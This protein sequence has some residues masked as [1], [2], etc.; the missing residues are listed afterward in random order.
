MQRDLR[1]TRATPRGRS[2]AGES[3]ASRWINDV[4]QP[5]STDDM[6]VS[7]PSRRSRAWIALA[8]GAFAF[9]ISWFATHRPGFGIPDF[10][11][12]WLAARALLDGQDPY[13]VVPQAVGTEFHFFYPLTAAVATL[14]F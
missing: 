4:M 2:P 13:V 3:S 9:G 8:L 6:A 12:W 1:G 7:G 14:P 11:S 10:H 5:A